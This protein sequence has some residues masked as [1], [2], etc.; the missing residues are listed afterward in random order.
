[1][2][3]REAVAPVEDGDAERDVGDEY[4]RGGCGR[5]QVGGDGG[6]GEGERGAGLDAG[7]LEGLARRDDDGV[8]HQRAGDGAEELLRRV[9]RERR[10]GH[11]ERR[12]GG[13][14]R[15]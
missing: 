8:R 11:G 12:G 9:G 2:R 6:R 13:A 1:M 5:G 4:E 7:A 10:R 15:R 3:Q 14:R